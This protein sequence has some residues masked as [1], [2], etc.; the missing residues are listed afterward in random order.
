LNNNLD[1]IIKGCL[2]HDLQSQ[3][4]LYRLCYTD[5]IKICYRYAKDVDAVGSIFNDAMLKV[6]KNLDNYEEQGKLMGW[7]KT[8]VVH[9][10]FDYCKKQIAFKTSNYTHV[11]DNISIEPEVFKNVSAKEIQLLIKKLPLA[12]AT[13]FNMHVYEGYTHKQIGEI[14]N[15]SDNTS[16]WHFSEAKKNLKTKLEK[17]IEIEF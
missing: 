13:V 3:E 10:C 11:N 6:F 5:M 12:T 1:N 9:T 2:K 4:Q 16:K 17:L 7:I 8:I 14:L 15:I